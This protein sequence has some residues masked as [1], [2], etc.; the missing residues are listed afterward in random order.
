MLAGPTVARHPRRTPPLELLPPT[1]SG[2]DTTAREP[3]LTG[4]RGLAALCVVATHAAFATGVLAHGYLGLL[5]ARLEIGV[6]I[7]FALSGFLLFRPW[8]LAMHTGRPA[9]ALSRYARHR[10]R[11]VA[12]G[13]LVTVLLTF[14]VYAMFALGPSPGQTWHGLVRYLTLTQ[15]YTDDFLITYLHPGLSQMWSLAVE[16]SFY[17]VLPPL[18]YL[19]LHVLC[20]HRWRP[21]LLLGGIGALAAIM[22]IWLI[23]VHAGDWLPNSA[24]MWLPAT[25]AWFAGGMMLAVLQATGMRCR[26]ATTLPLAL[27]AYL[28]VSTASLGGTYLAPES[29]WVP[30]T[31]ALLYGAIATLVLAPLVL[32]DAGRYPRLLS[33]R[34]MQ[35]LGEISYEIFLLHVVVMAVVLT[36]VLRWPL[37]TGSFAVLYGLTLAVTIPLAWALRRLTAPAR[38]VQAP[39]AP[40]PGRDATPRL[41]LP[42]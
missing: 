26:T 17:A 18:A 20:R 12:P 14:G 35:W 37:F 23:V 30:P 13:Y 34:G 42:C 27:L 33:S 25:L 32:G 16:V 38:A 19:L 8:V 1:P 15:I 4:L 39:A 31:K 22:P 6:P 10:V 11:R 9:P 28:A 3:A 21:T 40:A 41:S 5:F 7:F 36:L 2:A 29:V 24:G